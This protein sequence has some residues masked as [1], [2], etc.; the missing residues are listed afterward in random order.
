MSMQSFFLSPEGRQ[1]RAP[2][3]M[4]LFS[5][6]CL[7]SA[8]GKALGKVDAPAQVATLKTFTVLL[9]LAAIYSLGVLSAKRLHDLGRSG[10]WAPLYAVIPGGLMLLAVLAPQVFAAPP[11]GSSGSSLRWVLAY[12]VPAIGA[13]LLLEL[14]FR[15]GEPGPNAYGPVPTGEV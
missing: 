9:F 1:C 15:P 5:I 13:A 2:Y 7:V 3:A 6:T 8:L 10:W 14:L 12:G 4:G 11:A